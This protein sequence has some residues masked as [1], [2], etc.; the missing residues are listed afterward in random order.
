MLRGMLALLAPLSAFGQTTNDSVKSLLWD[1][2]FNIRA[3]LGYKDN[4]LLSSITQ[5]ESFYAATG[6]DAMIFRLPVNGTQF[7]LFVTGD[8]Y[9][10]LQDAGTDKEQTLIA[11]AKLQKSFSENW[12]AALAL[13]YLYQNQVLDVSATEADL[14]TV[15]LK[16][17]SIKATPSLKRKLP[18]KFG[19]QLELPVNRQILREPLDDYWEGG[20]KLT[21]DREYG[22]RSSIALSYGFNERFYDDREQ[23]DR[24]G[25]P[26]EG[27][28]LMFHQ[29]DIELSNR[30][31]WDKSRRWR[32]DTK[33]SFQLNEDNGTGFFDYYRYGLGEQLRYSAK[34]WNVQGGARAYLY[35]YKTQ[36][37]SSTD[38]SLRNLTS[39]SLT[40]RAEKNL[41]KSLKV[42]GQFEHEQSLSNRSANEYRANSVLT[43]LDWEF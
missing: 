12:E 39:L 21:L 34:S 20:P 4:V 17:H 42:Y 1:K 36:T 30:H 6:F 35:D 8:D 32:S 24:E 37:V 10:Y 18:Q 5:K 22:Q 14:A 15:Q 43:G 2:S 9:R 26:N 11:L 23:T 13:Q 27:T 41:I 28:S 40:L 29:H 25:V 7:Y 38:S 33:F 3:G 19:L 31:Y 16:G